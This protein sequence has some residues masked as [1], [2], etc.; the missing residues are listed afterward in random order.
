MKIVVT[1]GYALNPGDLSWDL[2]Q[3]FGDLIV[4]DRTDEADVVERC[5][6][7]EIILTNKVP[8]SI[9]A[10][11]SLPKLQMISV[12]ATGYNI[13][14]TEAARDQGIAV[15]NIPSYGTDSVAQHVFALL[16]ELTNHVC[17]NNAT[18]KEG[19]WQSSPDFS[20]TVKPI[21]E[22][23]GKTFGIIGFGNI[24]SRVARIAD[25]FGMKVIFQNPSRKASEIGVQLTLQEVFEQSDVLSLHC[26][27]KPDNKEFVNAAL[28]QKMKKSSFLINTSRGPLINEADL[29]AA[30]NDE[31][32]AGAALDVLSIE[33]P[34]DGNPLLESR[35]TI[36]TPHT[37]WISF[38]AR[39]RIM[40]MTAENIAGHIAGKPVNQVN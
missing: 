28:L 4:Y 32:I 2:L 9:D 35:N 3:K 24:G 25:A 11:R 31:I 39:K 12:L 40:E 5:N 38:E 20:Y 14:D 33:P 16:L 6:D 21:M 7:A 19:R 10:I 22:L 18:V 17:M 23:A 36:I 27:L 13:V 34:K 1:D 37:A 29:A 30:L 15:C 8:L 26:P